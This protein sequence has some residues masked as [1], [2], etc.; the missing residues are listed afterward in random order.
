M[1]YKVPLRLD[2]NI[3]FTKIKPI[4][5]YTFLYYIAIFLFFID[6]KYGKT[7]QII[8]STSDNNALTKLLYF[9]GAVES[10]LSFKAQSLWLHGKHRPAIVSE[11][12]LLCSTEESDSV[13]ELH[14]G[15]YS[16]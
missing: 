9:Y 14:K 4:S 1:L 11:F 7:V 16:E 8:P 6:S 15:E 13:L 3:W 12:L 10:F 5:V 2:M